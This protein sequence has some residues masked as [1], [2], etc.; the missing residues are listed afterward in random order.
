MKSIKMLLLGLVVGAL[1]CFS[2]GS[3]GMLDRTFS[4][5]MA[6]AL[7]VCKAVCVQADG[8]M[9][10]AG[11][12]EHEGRKCFAVA[13]MLP[14]GS[15]DQT[16]GS[17]G[18]TL[19]S[20]GNGETSSCAQALMIDSEGR[21]VAGGFSTAI[22]NIPHWCLARLNPNGSLDRSFFG[23]RAT[24]K[25]TVVTTFASLDE[26]S[27]INGLAECA[28][29]KIVAVGG[30]CAHDAAS[31]AVAR[32]NTNGSLDNTFNAAG[33]SGP[34]GTVCTQFGNA[35]TKNDEALAVALDP[36]GKILVGGSTHV[37]GVKTF[38]LARYNSDGSLDGSFFGG[39]A[40]VRGTVVTNFA[41]G[42][43]NACVKSVLIQADGKIVVGGY[44]NAKAA[45]PDLTHF[46]LARYTP[47]GKLDASFAADAYM[48]VPGTLITQFGS[49]KTASAVNAL[50]LQADGKIVAGGWTKLDAHKHPA[51]AR[52]NSDG[53]LDYQFNGGGAPA[54][55]V[56]TATPGSDSEICGLAFAHSGD[57]IA[58]GKNCCDARSNGVLMQY[59]CDQDICGPR[60]QEMAPSYFDGSAIQIS[61]TCHTPCMMR[62]YVNKKLVDTI[63]HKGSSTAWRYTLPALATGMYEVSAVEQYA[64]GKLHAQSNRVSFIVDQHP[65]T[66]DLSLSVCGKNPVSG[67]LISSGASGNHTYTIEYV[68]NGQVELNGADFIFNPSIDTGKAEFVYIAT[69]RVTGCSSRA[70]VAITVH[71][72]P[73][74]AGQLLDTC[75]SMKVYGNLLS[76]VTGGQSPY[77]ITIVEHP[78]HGLLTV[79]KDGSFSF[80]PAPEFVGQT[81][82]SYQV[83]DAHGATSPVQQLHIN[84]DPTPYACDLGYTTF[85]NKQVHGSVV[86]ENCQGVAPYEC[87][88]HS[89]ERGTV[90]IEK[91]GSFTFVPEHDFVGTA[92]FEYVLTDAKQRS[93]QIAKVV[94]DVLPIPVAKDSELHV[95][96]GVLTTGLLNQNVCDGNAPY[97]YELIST[98][99]D[100]AVVLH[101]DGSFE[102][103]TTTVGNAEFSYRVID[104]KGG[105][106]VPS[107]VRVMSHG[108]VVVQDAQFAMEND[109]YYK[110]SLAPYIHGGIPPYAIRLTAIENA[111]VIMK[112]DGTF[113]CVPSKDFT[114]DARFQYC[115]TDSL[116]GSNATG[117]VTI[118]VQKK[119]AVHEQITAEVGA[120][121]LLPVAQAFITETAPR[122]LSQDELN[123]VTKH[124]KE[125]LNYL[126]R[127]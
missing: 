87:M 29:G 108:P 112:P 97:T 9:V 113:T 114:G 46:A 54:G 21:I 93:S 35:Y 11:Y 110:A 42:E 53:S 6:Q 57:I 96:Q 4:H 107:T 62:I 1:P 44:T 116:K 69:D 104:S 56:I 14:N 24:F 66:K 91:D 92:Q 16:F 120:T 117:S 88:V 59:M 103:M 122:V 115:V 41:C 101:E 7:P 94:V 2:H 98:S 71:E 74:V 90:T 15:L 25:G 75:N 45:H 5:I 38:A 22:K 65:H 68:S 83:T 127:K 23:G 48:N 80:V 82:F 32:Y 19:V 47:H 49:D 26:M 118:H 64:G 124:K 102:C 17:Q 55:K 77:A 28:D 79:D 10:V 27:H 39:N 61:G 105:V 123:R 111:T 121:E 119:E 78:A 58:V 63:M 33:N 100:C 43:T 109:L 34:A 40:L 81:S 72:I 89:A 18:V 85:K 86:T 51:L 3:D 8:K 30:V 106:S 126:K 50:V 76:L 20:F 125:T 37:T 52:Y 36:Y 12:A 84:V 60:I 67:K 99:K 95:Y 73:A 13:R 31:F 70:K